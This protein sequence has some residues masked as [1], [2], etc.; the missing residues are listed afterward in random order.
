[1]FVKPLFLTCL[2]CLTTATHLHLQFLIQLTDMWP[3]N[4]CITYKHTYIYTCRLS[5]AVSE[6]INV[7]CLK[8]GGKQLDS[9]FD[10]VWPRSADEGCGVQT[11]NWCNAFSGS[12]CNSLPPRTSARVGQSLQWGQ[13]LCSVEDWRVESGYLNLS[14]LLIAMALISYV[15]LYDILCDI[16]WCLMSY[17]VISYVMSYYILYDI[18]CD[19][20]YLMWHLVICYVMSYNM[21]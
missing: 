15:I 12:F 5:A 2:C 13:A 19:I 11:E 10:H 18:L 4:K 21:W 17:L 20:L 16:L 8:V 6:F 1:M 3:L 14:C 7:F 9:V